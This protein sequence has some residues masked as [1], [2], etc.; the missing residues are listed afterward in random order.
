[1]TREGV[2]PGKIKFLS[3]HARACLFRLCPGVWD[4]DM[5]SSNTLVALQVLVLSWKT[6]DKS[7]TPFL[8]NPSGSLL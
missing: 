2:T 5:S 6:F 7:L 3:G 1:M 4:P 8:L